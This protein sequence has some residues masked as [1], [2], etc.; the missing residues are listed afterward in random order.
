MALP[1]EPRQL[2][3][4]LMYLVLTA[5]LA[6]NVSNEILN[7]FDVVNSSIIRSTG[8]TDDNTKDFIQNF[9]RELSNPSRRDKALP[10]YNAA[11]SIQE[12]S[13]ELT[14][15]I[16]TLKELVVEEAGG[17]DP[18]NP[19]K[20]KDPGN[21]YAATHIFVESKFKGKKSIDRGSELKSKIEEYISSIE[22]KIDAN[23][24]PEVASQLKSSLPVKI[25]EVEKSDNNPQGKWATGMFYRV[26]TTGALTVLSKFQNDISNAE[27][28]LIQTL[29]KKI[30]DDVIFIQGYK[31]VASVNNAYVMAGDK[32]T[33]TINLVPITSSSDRRN[34]SVSSGRVLP[35]P[36]N[37]SNT[38]VKLWETIASGNG[39]QTVTVR[40]PVTSADGRTTVE[41]AKMQYMV[42]SS[43]A[44]LQLDK[45]NVFY[46]GV[47][48]PITVSASGSSMEDVSVSIPGA[49]LKKTGLGK[50]D[51]T[52]DGLKA[53]TT[54][55]AVISGKQNGKIVKM[56][57]FPVRIKR[58]PDPLALFASKNNASVPASK[59]KVQRG[60]F[61]QLFN[62]DF[63]AR[64]NVVGYSLFVTR[65][66]GGDPGVAKG[67]RGAR[68]SPQAVEVVK[69][70]S[71]GDKLIID[72]IK[73]KGPDGEVRSLSPII[74]N[75][76]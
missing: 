30:S 33:G 50:Y 42:G 49:S 45:M 76:I 73:A 72:D 48:N 36:N 69:S 11:M 22:S 32:V 31:L 63:D 29:Y 60:V 14:A 9:E 8:N 1:K 61:A 43:G 19:K 56:G 2:M 74:L 54:V 25:E 3:I 57:Q 5:L 40:V 71:P 65:G 6:L 10:L 53:N 35:D 66:D 41:T 46:R 4:N 17:W 52:V 44:S 51:V 28:Q 75:A 47:S 26:P 62:F 24:R 55:D 67:I 64:F 7:A 70:I 38:N 58:I 12:E 20:A 39:M 23:F 34:F 59:L 18:E 13:K 37:T 68:L 21:I 16:E 15:Y 27:N